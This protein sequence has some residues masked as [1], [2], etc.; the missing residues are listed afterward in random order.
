MS[1]ASM[2]DPG[3]EGRKITGRMVLLALL[4]FFGVIFTV[5]GIMMYLAV[6]TF[7]GIESR[8]AYESGLLFEQ[9]VLAA[10]QQ[11]ELNWSVGAD[12]AREPTGLV[13]VTVTARDR[14]DAPVGGVAFRA[15]FEHRANR[16][17][18]RELTLVEIDTGT[19]RGSVT[20]VDRGQWTL[21]IEAEDAEK[22]VFRSESRIVFP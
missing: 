6:T 16:S 22:A 15:E 10:S 2:T 13:T 20:G 11:A 19:Y 7:S 21:I 14:Y 12:V 8:S 4:A 17:H 3:S 1:M 9:Q 5:N 18:D